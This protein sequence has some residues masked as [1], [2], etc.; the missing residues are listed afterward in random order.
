MHGAVGPYGG[1][2]TLKELRIEPGYWQATESSEVVLPCFH[3]DA[4][5]GGLTGAACYC[6][7]GYEGPYKAAEHWSRE[8][9]CAVALYPG[10]H[11]CS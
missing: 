1:T 9:V 7:E 6:R 11:T 5:L 3:T 8:V 4:C 2:N 10:K